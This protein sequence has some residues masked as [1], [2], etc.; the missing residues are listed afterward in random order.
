M[1]VLGI[2]QKINNIPT[3]E[4]LSFFKK[5]GFTARYLGYLFGS[6]LVK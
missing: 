6:P 2:S 1:D 3:E 4:K 5:L